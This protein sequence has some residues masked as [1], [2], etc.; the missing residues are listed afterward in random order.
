LRVV[1]PLINDGPQRRQIMAV[2]DV[3]HNGAPIRL[4]AKSVPFPT[5]WRRF[6][7]WTAVFLAAVIHTAQFAMAQDWPTRPV[8]MVVPFAA[9]SA[10]D[11]LARILG[12]RL[13]EVLGQ[14]VIIENVGGAGGM[15]GVA[16]VA[17]AAPD[18]YQFVLGGIDTFAQN[19]TLYK[20]PLY[21][22][23]NDFEPVALMVEQ[24][25]IL[26]TRNELP[27]KDLKEFTA[28]AKA[29]QA[30][31]QYGS[32]GAGSGSHLACA[33]LNAAIGVDVTH[34]PYR[35]SPPAMQDL[36]AGRIDYFCALAAAAM[37]QIS[38]NSMRAVAIL[39]RNRSPL[40]P[41]LASAHEQGLTDFDSYFWSG[42]FLPKGTP[43]TIVQKLHAAG[44]ATLDT[45]STQERLKEVGV[46][47]VAAERRSS[48][49]LKRFLNGEIEKWAVAIKA[50][51][52]S[53]D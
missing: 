51:G 26:V 35:G 3:G 28:Y 36:I 17:K 40:L 10:S 18:G 38:S 23:A 13:S 41:N 43:A 29:N 4:A 24:A 42:F 49:Y 19:Q 48:D 33:Q 32:A 27:V 52:V 31:M 47:V 20:K 30:K 22:S 34:V 14:Q 7:V 9:G 15:T 25:I 6:G 16:R 45:P 46:T 44:V 12:A 21:N 39:T 53:L 5:R 37:P 11:T 2:H 8:T 50:S 1:Q